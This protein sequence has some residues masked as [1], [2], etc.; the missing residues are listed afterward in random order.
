MDVYWSMYW[1]PAL[2]P[3]Q[4]AVMQMP[5]QPLDLIAFADM[6][7]LDPKLQLRVQQA[8]GVVIGIPTAAQITLETMRIR[9]GQTGTSA[10]PFLLQGRLAQGKHRAPLHLIGQIA[11]HALCGCT[12]VCQDA[13]K[14]L[15][16]GMH[17][18]PFVGH[19]EISNSAVRAGHS[20]QWN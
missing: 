16:A 11:W 20:R 10:S 15:V 2:Q 4:G 5:G 17:R 3:R 8:S 18:A 14:L 6:F 1:E 13:H 19:S 9:T 12:F 7:D